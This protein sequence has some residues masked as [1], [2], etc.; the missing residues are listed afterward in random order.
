MAAMVFQAEQMRSGHERWVAEKVAAARAAHVDSVRRSFPLLGALAAPFAGLSHDLREARLAGRGARGES[1]V[2]S[3]LARLLPGAWTVI[4]GACVAWKGRTAEV[5]VLAVG[6]PGVAVVEVKAWRG[7]FWVEG[8]AWYRCAGGTWEPC[9]SP[10]EQVSRA[11]HLVAGLLRSLSLDSAMVCP[12]VVMAASCRV[13]GN[14]SPVPV[15]ADVEHLVR[16]LEGLP[17]VLD[18]EGVRRVLRTLGCCG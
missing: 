1:A 15:Y 7:D 6:P 14:G 5:D 18:S 16:D 2:S 8:A 12:A 10:A 17:A 13:Q 4:P 11:A 9:R 3:G